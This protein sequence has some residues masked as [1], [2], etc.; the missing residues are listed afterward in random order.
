M[1]FEG[2][3][4]AGDFRYEFEE[5]DSLT[6]G[7]E[8]YNVNV[9]KVTGTMTGETDEFLGMSASAEMV[10]DGYSYDLE[11]GMA[12]V[13]EDMYI[14]ANMTIDTDLLPVTTRMETQDVTTYSPPLMSGFLDGETGTGD[15][16]EETTNVTTSSTTWVDGAMD[17][18]LSDEYEETYS[19]SVAA[20]EETVTTDAGTFS[21]LKMT[22]IDES[23]DYVVYWYSSD[24]GAWVKM[25]SYSMGETTPFMT[26]ELVEYSHGGLSAMMVMLVVGVVIAVVVVVV[27]I[28][29]MMRRG[30][31]PSPQQMPPPPPTG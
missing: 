21:C 16:W 4:V 1:D 14:W 30:R 13:K 28:M 25:S 3:T 9:M 5:K 10:F 11:G 7:S 31:T 27:V 19:I 29:L 23:D 22:V 15:E 6:V 17:S 12:T 26:L 18:T 2:I 24:V 20:A 8:T